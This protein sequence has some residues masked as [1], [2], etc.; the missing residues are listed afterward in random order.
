MNNNQ[1]GFAHLFAIVLIILVLALVGFVGGRVFF[2]NPGFKE[3]ATQY[4]PSPNSE[5]TST[6]PETDNAVI[7]GKKL[8]NGFCE[9]KGDGKFT[10]LPM[11]ANDFSMLTPYGLTVGGHVTP[12]DHQYF[13]PTV[14]HS[15]KDAYSV[16]AMANSRITGIEVHPPE[17]GGNGRIR[18]VFAVSCT[19]LYYYDLVTSVESGIDLSHVPISVKAGQLIGHIGGQTLDFAVWNT[20]K[21]LSGFVD[22]NS[23]MGEPW[24]I[25]TADPFPYYTPDLRQIV[26]SKDPRIADPIAGKIDYDIDGK[27]IGNWFIQ[28]GGGYSG[29]SDSADFNYFKKHLSLAPDLYDPTATVI[30]VGDYDSYPGSN[31]NIKGGDGSGARQFFAKAG[32]LDPSKIGQ[33]DGLV[34]FEFVQRNYLTANGTSWDRLTLTKGPKADLGGPIVG[35]ALFQMTDGRTLKAEVFPGKT[36]SQASGFD[37]NAKIY[38]R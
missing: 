6:V 31:V 38:T 32:S 16:Y 14:F 17:N 22:P 28:G 7:A 36:A 9:G 37:S 33:S 12:I 4:P 29:R 35:T 5:P 23:Y 11:N 25:Y 26:V 13:Q 19:F 27:L 30:S 3:Q 20:T 18:L 1:R 2:K 10:H 24:K 21:P 15:A 34:K 8:S